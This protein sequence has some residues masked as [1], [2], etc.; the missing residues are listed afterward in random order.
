V[1]R[2]TTTSFH[3]T[4]PA[5][6]YVPVIAGV[7]FP[8]SLL[9]PAAVV[10]A[11]RARAGWARA[12]RL[13]VTWAI[14]VVLFFSIS[15]S[16]LPGYVLTAVL[17]LGVLAARVVAFAI[18][19][20]HGRAAGIVRHGLIVLAVVGAIVALFLAAE[21]RAP[22]TFLPLF[23][24]RP[25]ELEAIRPAFPSL[26]WTF[27]SVAILAMA[28]AV[29]LRRHDNRI[30]RACTAITPF[31]LLPLSLV[32]VVFGGVRQYAEARSARSLASRISTLAPDVDVACLECLPTGLPFYLERPV[33]VITRDGRETTSNYV[34]FSLSRARQWPPVI[35]PLASRDQWLGER[36][37]A[38]YLL[39]NDRRRA[40]LD[41]LAGRTGTRSVEIAPGWWGAQ[42]T[43]GGRR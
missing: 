19:S 18:Q 34:M 1:A 7:F 3:R 39:A 28:A 25:G 15:Q 10:A 33:A 2:F 29:I 8:W 24:I 43:F 26:F 6:Y 11:W 41:S 31:V 5:Y 35:V 12:D 42:L 23:R 9:L 37:Q 27:A 32:S 30:V 17:A 4:A 13:F 36:Q 38:I 40:A 14:V 20:A 22:S 16:K 21:L